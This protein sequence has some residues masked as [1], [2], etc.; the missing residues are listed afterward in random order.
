MGGQQI[1]NNQ[2]GIGYEPTI[3][4]GINNIN[5]I[6]DRNIYNPSPMVT[7]NNMN[8]I[9]SINNINHINDV[10]TVNDIYSPTSLT[11]DED[12]ILNT[13]N[14][15]NEYN[16]NNLPLP[17]SQLP[18]DISCSSSSTINELNQSNQQNDILIEDNYST[19]DPIFDPN[20]DINQF[21][22]TFPYD[23]DNNITFI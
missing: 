8:D 3:G 10:N 7:A 2:N 20:D 4:N 13:N 11:M 15:V 6:N 19:F 21:H 16:D 5:N 9:N 12:I 23:D 22:H 14:M 18:N 1:Y 17:Q